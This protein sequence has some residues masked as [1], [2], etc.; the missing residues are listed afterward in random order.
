M[1]G[2]MTN[3]YRLNSGVWQKVIREMFVYDINIASLLFFAEP[4]SA[5][6]GRKEETTE[7]MKKRRAQGKSRSTCR[8]NIDCLAD[9]HQ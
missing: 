6:G 2:G 9:G 1:K 8:L 4:A 5:K 7:G 3:M